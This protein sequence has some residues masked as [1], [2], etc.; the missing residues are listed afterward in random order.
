M[1]ISATQQ[2]RKAL[3]TYL[4]TIKADHTSLASLRAI[5][6]EHD[7][8]AGDLDARILNLEQE[9]AH[10]DK[11]LAVEKKNPEANNKEQL[12]RKISITVLAQ[13][14]GEVTFNV[15]YRKYF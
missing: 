8:L 15:K 10:V 4:E 9:V 13:K 2:T 5:F 7:K 3:G 11:L 1:Q 6:E 12:T 14:A